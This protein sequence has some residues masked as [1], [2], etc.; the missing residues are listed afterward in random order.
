M[1]A[2]IENPHMF[3]VVVNAEGKLI[4]ISQTLLNLLEMT[5]EEALGKY[6]LDVIP[7]GKLPEVLRTGRI[8]DADVLW[9]N[10]HKTIVTRVPIYKNGEIVGAVCSSLFMDISTA[11][12][13]LE[14]FNTQVPE[15]DL[16]LVLNELID[17]PSIG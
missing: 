9:V 7:D 6:I 16:D 5:E 1:D 12:D 15:P 13:L 10:G 3:F 8:H 17:N 11:Q 14:R 2:M 4:S